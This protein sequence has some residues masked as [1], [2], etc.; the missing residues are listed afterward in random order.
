MGDN[1]RKVP[2]LI[3]F[4][5]ISSILDVLGIGLI[6]PYVS[7]LVD[8]GIS[9]PKIF[10][11][12]FELFGI[13]E[14]QPNDALIYT[15][16]ILV[17]IFILKG[18]TAIFINQRILKFCFNQG[19]LLRSHLFQSY[20][21]LPYEEHLNRNSSENIRNI[22]LAAAFSHG[23]LQSFLRFISEGIVML[24]VVIFLAYQNPYVLGL[25]LIL[26][27]GVFV[28]YDFFFKRNIK[29]YGLT[30]NKMHKRIVKGVYEGIEGLKEIKILGKEKYFYQIVNKS[31]EKFASVGVKSSVIAAAP[32]YL[33]ESLLV[34]FIVLLVFV[35][36]T[37]DF[38]TRELL[39]LLSMFGLASIRL[40]PSANQM[41]S[42]MSKMRFGRNTVSLLYKDLKN[43]EKY[44]KNI[45][46]D[47]LENIDDF[48]S[49]KLIDVCY[50]F[51]N[52]EY[53]TLKNIS[54]E[55]KKGD[56]IAFIG[57]SGAGKTT[58]VN[59]ITGLIEPKNGDILYN[60][61]NLKN[62]AAG[63]MSQIAY[64]PQQVF[65]IDDTILNNVALGECKLEIDTNRAINALKQA[66]LLD[67]L[68]TL[69]Q[70]VDT[71][72]GE[73]GVRLS[74][75]QRQRL[76]LARAFYFGRDVLVLDEST[77]SLDETIEKEI[78]EEIKQLKGK[79]TVIVIAHRLSTV[80]HCNHIYQLDNGRIINHGSYE[81]VLG[82]GS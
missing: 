32:R 24:V 28:L 65:I 40:A 11:E 66:K 71:K 27:V 81:D 17:F 54:L 74:G 41:I 36:I 64:L 51:P 77:S 31:A 73:R 47:N 34:L 50:S 49:L 59:I 53:V 22:D 30:A 39:P 76:A 20:Q 16:W 80:E 38:D 78:I 35:Y 14:I 2:L 42:G 26:L 44:Q 10:Y 68:D 52:T 3:G 69:P 72:I 70:G 67:L 63:W 58:L 19:S 33:I 62:I 21:N 25:L 57:S 79:K 1:V 61:V 4:F 48:S 75:G 55:I 23:L 29:Q 60:N 12:I 37:F 7:L 15:G 13:K 56:S 5:L 18:V 46:T 6:A 43:L 45:K 9:L 8:S 82:R